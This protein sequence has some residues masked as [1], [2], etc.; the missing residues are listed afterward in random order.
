M[1]LKVKHEDNFDGPELSLFWTGGH[2][3]RSDEVRMEINKGLIIDFEQGAQYASA[4]VVSKK[5]IDGDFEAELKF[6]VKNPVHGSTFEL[7]AIQV[8]PPL[9]TTIPSL[10]ITDAH[11]VYNVHGSPPY[12]S[13]EFDEC[14]G[15]RIGW[16]Y[17]NKQ[18]GWDANGE[19]LSDNSDNEYGES[20]LGPVT[21]ETSGWL[22]L[23]RKN[24]TE[25]RVSCR[26]FDTDDWIEVDSQ[27]TELL[28]GPIYLRLV[29][30]HWV[31]HRIGATIAPA[32]SVLFSDFKLWN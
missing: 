23:S 22:K 5:A 8:A 25:W 19:W 28:S 7:A 1:A 21:G 11:R 24:G 32:N 16:N 12:I 4:G 6:I 3:N 30:K 2:F 9:K 13:S 14:D 20:K 10:I 15:W 31:K 27:I 29:A 17:G 18:G 26:K